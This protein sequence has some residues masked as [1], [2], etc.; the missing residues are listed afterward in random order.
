MESINQSCEELTISSD[1]MELLAQLLPICELT[2]QYNRDRLT[3]ALNDAERRRKRQASHDAVME[4]I[5]NYRQT[6][7]DQ[8]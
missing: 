3:R 8:R 2:N 6:I 7:Q 1:N 5:R 4:K